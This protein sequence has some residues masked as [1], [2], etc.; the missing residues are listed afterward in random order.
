[1]SEHSSSRKDSRGLNALIEWYCPE[2]ACSRSAEEFA[3]I[4]KSLQMARPPLRPVIL[5]LALYLLTVFAFGSG[6]GGFFVKAS[7]LWAPI[8]LV[9][10]IGFLFS[11]WTL[12]R[13][14]DTA[15]YYVRL[16]LISHGVATCP[17]CAYDLTGIPEPRSCCPECG[18]GLASSAVSE[19]TNEAE[20]RETPPHRS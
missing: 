13:A 8:A 9:I 16:Y 15:R 20:A 6:F 18:A 12:M 4:S 1:M 10:V 17:R 7:T 5:P 11:L 3:D 19:E 14:R 2:F